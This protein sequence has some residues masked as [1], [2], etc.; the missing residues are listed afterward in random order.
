MTRYQVA[1]EAEVGTRGREAQFQNHEA[2]EVRAEHAAL[3]QTLANL[4]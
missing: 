2:E 4:H 1:K 3:L